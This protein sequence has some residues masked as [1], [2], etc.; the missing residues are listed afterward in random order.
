MDPLR[1]YIYVDSTYGNVGITTAQEV[2]G[3]ASNTIIGAFTGSNIA[4]GANVNTIVGYEA[5]GALTTGSSNIGV[6]QSSCSN[7]DSGN[8]NT[9]VGPS[10]LQTSTDT[11]E[12]VV[13]G[14]PSPT[15]GNGSNTTTIGDTSTTAAYIYGPQPSSGTATLTINSTGLLSTTT[16]TQT[17]FTSSRFLDTVYQNTTG[18]NIYVSGN[19][20]ITGGAGDSEIS[21]LDGPDSG[22]ADTVWSTTAAF[23][24][25][26]EPVG[27]TCIIPNT[28]YYEISEDHDIATT[29]INWYETTLP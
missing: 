15:T 3:T 16:S 11:N 20:Q 4:S 10:Q 28:Y 7:V 21:C 26:G 18:S 19:A 5:L 22:V 8:G 9:C 6:G 27:F 12:I 14:G 17:N 13:S 1:N 29:P 24:V 2:A 25:S 23:T